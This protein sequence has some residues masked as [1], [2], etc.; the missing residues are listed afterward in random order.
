MTPFDFEEITE[1]N[2][3]IAEFMEVDVNDHEHQLF[4]PDLYDE[5]W[6]KLMPVV[7]KIRTLNPDAGKV[8]F[9][10]EISHCHCR[11]WNNGAMEW[12][13]NAGTT[14]NATWQTVVQF[15]QWY[16]QNKK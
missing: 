13:N 11:I 2:K 15:I 14:I 12:K 5:D 8:W 3:L 16:N 6:N 1:G 10:W 7:E 9:E 4:G